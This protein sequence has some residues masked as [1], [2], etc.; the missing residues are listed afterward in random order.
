[1]SA[2]VLLGGGRITGALVAGLR[3]AGYDKPIV[4]HDRH[5]GKLRQLKKRYAIGTEPDLHRA[6]A[7]ANLLVVAVRPDSVRSLLRSMGPVDRPVTAVSLAAGV[8]LA[9]LRA[10]TGS[11]VRW[12]RAMPSP[13]CRSGLGLT[14]VTFERGLGPVARRTIKQF[15]GKV[16]AVV[17]IPESRFDAFTVTYSS[18]HGLHALAA[19]AHASQKLGLDRKTAFAAAAHALADGIV[20]WREGNASLDHLLR[21]AATPGGI[22]AT[23]M[24]S[25][26]AAGYGLAVHQALRAGMRR[27]R[28]NAKP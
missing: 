26:D 10:E 19:L 28:K 25:M 3:L 16:G 21:E 14:A 15:F 23:V 22:A 24:S 7:Q 6:V 12:A 20:A 4:V 5:A 2:T 11:K 27:A 8:P 9:K 13:V 18:S 17:E 1:M